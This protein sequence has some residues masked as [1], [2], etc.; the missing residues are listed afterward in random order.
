MKQPE[1]KNILVT[2][3]LGYIGSNTIVSLIE[4]G[5]NPIIIDDL[6]NS[7]LSRLK[8]IEDITKSDIHYYIGDIKAPEN[9]NNLSYIMENYDIYS[10]IHFAAFKS[11]N[12]SV[13]NPLKYYNNNIYGA[14]SL[15]EKMKKYNVKNIIFSSSCTVYGEPDRYPVD[16]K[17]PIKPAESPY[18]ET[19]QICEN[20]LR[21][22]SKKED[23][24]VVSLRYFNPI[25]CHESGLLSDNPKGIPESLMPYIVGVL[26]KEYEYLRIFGNDYNTKDGT[27]IRDYIDIT[28][29]AEAHVK[30]LDIVHKKDYQTINVGSGCGHSVMEMIECFKSLG[31]EIPFKIFPRRKGDIESIYGDVSKAQKEMSWTPQKDLKE[32]VLS[33]IKSIV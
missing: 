32:T 10:V 17:S 3:G 29:L 1:N 26:K 9:L 6:S 24:N 13:K 14:I 4:N 15:L 33:I 11:V 27:A 31:H 12:E 19:K 5:Y 23:I 25:G 30:A 2:G 22:T 18:G 21:G 16:E 20:I 7:E 28:D 8:E